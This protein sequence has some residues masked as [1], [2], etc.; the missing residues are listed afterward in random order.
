M[1]VCNGELWS[2]WNDIQS[3]VKRCR[4]L[5]LYFFP[6]CRVSDQGGTEFTL[7]AALQVAKCNDPKR[8]SKTCWSRF[9]K[10]SSRHYTICPIDYFHLIS[11]LGHLRTVDRQ[12]V[13]WKFMVSRKSLIIKQSTPE[14]S[15]VHVWSAGL[16][17][18]CSTPELSNVHVWSAG[19]GGECVHSPKAQEVLFFQKGVEKVY[20]SCLSTHFGHFNNSGSPYWLI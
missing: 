18:E 11:R 5:A 12:E 14:L 4:I 6:K 17:G 13:V 10:R 1:S 2:W 8:Q 16:G 15:N 7:T 20:L 9:N 19:L 3:L